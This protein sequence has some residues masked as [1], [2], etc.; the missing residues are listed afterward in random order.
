MGRENKEQLAEP[1]TDTDSAFMARLLAQ[2]REKRDQ[3]V[4]LPEMGKRKCR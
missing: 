4:E 2:V 1:L 3:A